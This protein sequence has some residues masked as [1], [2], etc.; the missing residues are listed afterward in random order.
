MVLRHVPHGH[1][2]SNGTVGFAISRA[3]RA[4]E[5]LYNESR[6]AVPENKQ[7]ARLLRE[8]DVVAL[9]IEPVYARAC[10]DKDRCVGVR[11]S[12]ATCVCPPSM[13]TRTM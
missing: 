8:P 1:N 2:L 13:N 12:D 10:A 3:A 11:V 5:Q 9:A 4:F 7:W 6:Q